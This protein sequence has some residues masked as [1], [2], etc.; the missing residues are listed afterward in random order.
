MSGVD[1][2]YFCSAKR[3]YLESGVD[4]KFRGFVINSHVHGLVNRCDFCTID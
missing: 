2:S 4:N 1:I 3:M